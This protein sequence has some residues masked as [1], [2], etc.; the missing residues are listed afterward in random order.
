[1]LTPSPNFRSRTR[2]SADG[3]PTPTLA[4]P[5]TSHGPALLLIAL[6]S[7]PLL[8]LLL[9]T[10]VAW[11]AASR[12]PVGA[13]SHAGCFAHRDCARGEYCAVVPRADGFATQ[14]Q[15]ADPC[16]EDS[17]CLNGW[18]CLEMVESTQGTLVPSGPGTRRRVCLDRKRLGTP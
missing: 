15:C 16:E 17:Q 8:L 12:G 3:T 13:L 10:G 7:L 5:R 14:G 11:L 9:G 4:R 18:G 2:S 6:F 1:M